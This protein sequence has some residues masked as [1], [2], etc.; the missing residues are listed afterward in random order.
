VIGVAEPP[1]L[2]PG[3][4]VDDVDGAPLRSVTGPRAPVV[5]RLNGSRLPPRK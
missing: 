1:L 3:D 4:A 5:Q 2:G